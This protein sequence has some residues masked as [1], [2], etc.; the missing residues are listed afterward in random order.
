MVYAFRHWENENRDRWD[1]ES[2]YDEAR[3]GCA[4]GRYTRHWDQDRST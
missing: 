4:Y 1:D 2:C 3:E